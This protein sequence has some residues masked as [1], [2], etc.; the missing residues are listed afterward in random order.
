MRT[1]YKYEMSMTDDIQTFDLYNGYSIV[2]FGEQDGKI[3]MWVDH[4]TEYDTKQ[5]VKLQII[6]TGHD[7]GDYA[8]SYRQTVQMPNGLVWHIYERF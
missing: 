3:M 1:I 6:G 8:A 7:I 2:H 4:R 5:L